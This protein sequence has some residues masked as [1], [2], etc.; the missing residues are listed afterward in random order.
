MLDAA[1]EPP[2]VYGLEAASALRDTGRNVHRMA[3]LMEGSEDD[4]ANVR[5][6]TAFL[7]LQA[8]AFETRH[9]RVQ[10]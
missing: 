2:Q 6:M 7:E 3:A 9:H 10:G 8:A 5:A 4:G 1:R